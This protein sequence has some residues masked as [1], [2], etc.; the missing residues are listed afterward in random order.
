MEADKMNR[1]LNTIKQIAVQKMK[2]EN[3]ANGRNQKFVMAAAYEKLPIAIPEN[4]NEVAPVLD[5]VFLVVKEKIADE[6]GNSKKLMELYNIK[7][8]LIITGE[9]GQRIKLDREI[10]DDLILK[11]KQAIEEAGL[12]VAALNSL[13]QEGYIDTFF[14]ILGKK[15]AVLNKE[16]EEKLRNSNE[17]ELLNESISKD[18]N[19]LE[20]EAKVITE[21]EK[22]NERK[23]EEDIK[24]GVGASMNITVVKTM[25]IQD[26][27][28]FKNNPQLIGK[29]VVAVLDNKNNLRIAVNEGGVY[30]DAEGLTEYSDQA[31]RT[32]IIY[33]DTQPIEVKNTYGKVKSK[34]HDNMTY[35]A[36]IDSMGHLGLVEQLQTKEAVLEE[37]DKQISRNVQGEH[38]PISKI[39]REGIGTDSVTVNTFNQSSTN[40]NA[41]YYGNSNNKGGVADKISINT[42]HGDN[43]D[44]TMEE[45]STATHERMHIALEKVKPIVEQ[46]L[47]ENNLEMTSKDEEKIK[48]DI[49][50]SIENQ[51]VVFCNEVVE[52]Y[53]DAYVSEKIAEKNGKQKPEK[54]EYEKTLS[55]DAMRRRF[56]DGS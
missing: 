32:K 8:D 30:K 28:F 21:K 3:K 20:P 52:I 5:D 15:L 4:V 17:R 53:S 34:T 31:G 10:L 40:K 29:E 49:E 9:E 54:E 23:K 43:P 51:N 35:A 18:P 38:T 25:E 2:D 50:K 6:Y 37:S 55:G 19:E 24:A 26:S 42:K 56:G 13:D 7:G 47:R 11:E 45:M 27:L 12:Q 46:K 33:E 44:H 41:N 16:G 14:E 1:A 36:T 22:S 48:T 39:N